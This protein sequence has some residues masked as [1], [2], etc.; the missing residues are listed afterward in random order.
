MDIECPF[1]KKMGFCF[2]ARKQYLRST[3]PIFCAFCA[4]V[5]GSQ[6]ALKVG[7]V[8]RRSWSHQKTKRQEAVHSSWKEKKAAT[9][10]SKFFGAFAS[11]QLDEPDALQILR[12]RV[13]TPLK[14]S[15]DCS[16]FF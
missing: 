14:S 2:L 4:L 15:G 8:E 16:L 5:P 1:S 12:A 10:T 7:L 11:S 3:S 13:A 6:N 9:R